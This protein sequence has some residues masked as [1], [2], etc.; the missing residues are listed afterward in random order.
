GA[1]LGFGMLWALGWATSW[2]VV[3]PMRQLAGV[4]AEIRRG[5]LESRAQLPTGAGEVGEVGDALR[6][7]SERVA[8]QL[9]DQRALL[10]AVS[11][12]LRSPLAAVKASVSSLRNTEVRFSDEDRAELLENIES[13]TDRLTALVT[14]LLDMSRIQT[15]ALTMQLTE[16]NLS[17]ACQYAPTRALP[18][19][20][21][22]DSPVNRAMKGELISKSSE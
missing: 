18:M 19:S 22:D 1:F 20:E 9:Q 4:A 6:G 17:A 5:H 7:V 12:D 21:P 3:W 10:A 14:N 11:H 16:V 8:K 13:S 2:R 15:G